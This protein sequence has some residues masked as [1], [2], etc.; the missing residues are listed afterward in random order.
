M[1]S[2]R[3]QRRPHGPRPELGSSTVEFMLF[4]FVFIP[5]LLYAL[6][7]TDALFDWLKAQEAVGVAAWEFSGELLH[8]YTSYDHTSKYATAIS[9]VSK[10]KTRYQGLDG[11]NS[12]AGSKRVTPATSGQLQDL[13]CKQVSTP[14]EP[15]AGSAATAAFPM[16]LGSKLHTGGMIQCQSSVSIANVYFGGK[17]IQDYE[18]QSSKGWGSKVALYS[19]RMLKPLI[20]C[21]VGTPTSGGCSTK[22]GFTLLTDDWGLGEDQESS[23]NNDQNTNEPDQSKVNAHFDGVGK[24]V[25]AALD[26]G[27]N[28][29]W[30]SVDSVVDPPGSGGPLSPMGP[31]LDTKFMQ[32]LLAYEGETSSG[33]GT[34]PTIKSSS[35]ITYCEENSSY[36]QTSETF[37]MHHSKISP[38]TS[39]NATYNVDHGDPRTNK[40]LAL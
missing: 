13:T 28:P 12:S 14:T 25:Y 10:V 24:A 5:I 40:Y 33:P 29:V 9:N 31:T 26:T 19:S 6:Y 18:D 36:D 37:P 11:W 1:I 27:Q 17:P 23:T 22:T 15:L 20:L 4:L 2:S 16:G 3:T 38:Q 8:D 35:S 30:S 7:I 39:D 32:F 34:G 21:G